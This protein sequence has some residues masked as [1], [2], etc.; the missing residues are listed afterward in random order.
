M[1]LSATTQ[2]LIFYGGLT[3]LLIAG[4]LYA[5]M[6]PG[7]HGDGLPIESLAMH[8]AA[9]DMKAHVD[10]LATVVGECTP[11]NEIDLDG[12]SWQT[13]GR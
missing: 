10:G 13:G 6:M 2:R 5:T 8:A 4:Y 12:S 1:K 3:S 7:S 9:R 11:S